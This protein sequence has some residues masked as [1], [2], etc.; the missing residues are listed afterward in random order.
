[1]SGRDCPHLQAITTVKHAKRRECEECVKI[2]SGWVHLRTCQE[3]G[4]TLCCDSSPNRHATKHFRAT[5]HPII[6][7]YDPP[8]AWGW[9]YVD[10]I[11]FDLSGRTTPHNGPIPRYV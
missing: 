10:E 6:E 1:V 8:E 4:R 2:G 9:C 3:C 5:H 11:T 7:G